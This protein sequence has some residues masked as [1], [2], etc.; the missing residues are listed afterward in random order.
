MTPK[1]LDRLGSLT[2]STIMV[3]RTF[4]SHS[5]VLFNF[6]SLYLFAIGIMLYLGLPEFYLAL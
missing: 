2:T 4:N 1:T 5:K 6:P 3:S